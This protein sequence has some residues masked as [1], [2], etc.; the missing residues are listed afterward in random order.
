MFGAE[1]STVSPPPHIFMMISDDNNY[2]YFSQMSQF[3]NSLYMGQDL[4]RLALHN[5]SP[6]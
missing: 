2:H 4:E 5:L 1:T 6:G 3:F